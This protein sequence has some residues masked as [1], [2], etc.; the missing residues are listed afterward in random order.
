MK[1]HLGQLQ[2][3]EHGRV[4]GF[5]TGDKSFRNRLMA[6]GLTRGT[7]FQVVRMAPLGDPVEIRVRGFSLSLRR[8]EAAI[9]EV[10]PLGGRQNR[11]MPA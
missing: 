4:T 7:E 9:V 11:G 10:Q 8:G 5:G 2:T 6:M 3:G 1:T